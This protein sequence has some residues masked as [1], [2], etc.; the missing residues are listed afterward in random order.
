MARRIIFVTSTTFDGET[1]LFLD[2]SGRPWLSKPYT[3]E[4][5]TRELQKVLASTPAA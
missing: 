5:M 4:A 1:S 2:A 3:T